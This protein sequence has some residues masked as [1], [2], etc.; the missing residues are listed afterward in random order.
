MKN[1]NFV[2]ITKHHHA[3]YIKSSVAIVFSNLKCRK[4]IYANNLARNKSKTLNR[5]DDNDGYDT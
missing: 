4:A 1:N 3:L 2:Y 5:D